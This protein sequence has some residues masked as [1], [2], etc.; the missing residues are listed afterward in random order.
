VH[1]LQLPVGHVR[2][3]LRGLDIGVPEQF[4]HG[5][6]VRTV[7]SRIGCE[8]VAQGVRGDLLHDAGQAGILFDAALDGAGGQAKTVPVLVVQAGFALLFRKSGMYSSFLFFR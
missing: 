1:L 6:Q 2:I 7:E 8:G 5:P 4:L 3:D